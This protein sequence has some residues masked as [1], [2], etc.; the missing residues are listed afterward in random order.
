M[1]EKTDCFTEMLVEPPRSSIKRAHVSDPLI[2]VLLNLVIDVKG[3]L[4]KPAAPVLGPGI[5]R[6]S[7]WRNPWRLLPNPKYEG[8]HTASV[9]LSL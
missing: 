5:R 3:P 8:A 6:T 1:A 2:Q 9:S 4:D 7:P